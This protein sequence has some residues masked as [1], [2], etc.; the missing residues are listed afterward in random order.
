MKKIK[1][2]INL[3]YF[4][5]KSPKRRLNISLALGILVNL[6]YLGGNIVSAVGYRSPWAISI[7]AYHLIFLLMRL[8]LVCSGRK[9]PV[10]RKDTAICLFV[11][12]L[13]FVLDIFSLAIIM[14]TISDD[15]KVRYSGFILFFFLCYAV[16]SLTSSFLGMKKWKYDNNILHFAA[17]NLSFASALMSVFNL[18]FSLISSLGI[19]SLI[20]DRLIYLGGFSV[21]SIIFVLSIRLMVKGRP[22]FLR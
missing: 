13:L 4:L 19:N 14:Y 15:G 17:K 7:T 9:S 8:Y 6:V 11:G 3:I 12:V 1:S 10:D 18:Q 22:S 5:M 21:F 16:Y 2:F 20:G